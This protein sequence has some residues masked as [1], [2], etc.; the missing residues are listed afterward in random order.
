VIE[1]QLNPSHNQ[2]KGYGLKIA[3]VTPQGP[4]L[5]S[6]VGTPGFQALTRTAEEA[7]ASAKEW[8]QQCESA[9]NQVEQSRYAFVGAVDPAACVVDVREDLEY[10]RIECPASSGATPLPGLYSLDVSF[11]DIQRFTNFPGDLLGARTM[12]D[13]AIAAGALRVFATFDDYYNHK[14]PALGQYRCVPLVDTEA[15]LEPVKQEALETSKPTVLFPT[16]WNVAHD[17]LLKSMGIRVSTVPVTQE[18]GEAP[19]DDAFDITACVAPP[20]PDM[21]LVSP[22]CAFDR[23]YRCLLGNPGTPEDEPYYVLDCYF[24]AAPKAVT[25]AAGA[26]PGRTTGYKRVRFEDMDAE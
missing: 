18:E 3:K 23:G 20:S 10:L 11:A 26:K 12:V 17:N 19:H 14:E 4:T 6:Y 13:L 24:N 9:A 1:V 15:L 16:L 7:S 2:A 22:A 25:G 5:Y 8:A 21:A